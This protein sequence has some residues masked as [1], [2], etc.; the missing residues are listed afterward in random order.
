MKTTTRRFPLAML[1]CA[2]V[3]IA[4]VP[5][6]QAAT[7]NHG[8]FPAVTVDY[9]DV[10]EASS[11]DPV[12]LFGSPMTFG[13]QLRFFEPGAATPSLG[14]GANA[15]G[16]SGDVT[17]GFLS[18]G[19]TARPLWGITNLNISESG[20]YSMGALPPSL[21]QVTAN[22][23]V[24]SVR[25]D[26]VDNVALVNPI[27]LSGIST[28]TYTH[29]P[30]SPVAFWSN[31]LDFD[32]N[33]AL[34]AEGLSYVL[35]ATALTVR[36]N[37]TLIALSQPGSAANIVKKNFRIT[38]ETELIPEPTTLGM[39]LMGLALIAVSRRRQS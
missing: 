6:A 1:A 22:L 28:V 23:V 32:L 17:D 31:S 5:V 15:A 24:E 34:D 3:C 4:T 38:P 36:L 8:N 29:P 18:F 10:T 35:G 21:A 9:L 11:T 26:A 2:L 16:G 39:A 33:A 30:D 7:I 20:D 27:L 12:P 13:D 14:F 19:M 25:I 37:D